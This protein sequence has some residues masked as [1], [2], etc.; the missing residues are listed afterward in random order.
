MSVRES[1]EFFRN[2]EA[3]NLEAPS[4]PTGS[5]KKAPPISQGKMAVGGE[6]VT[7]GAPQEQ[8]DHVAP[9]MENLEKN[10]TKNVVEDTQ[11]EKDEEEQGRPPLHPG[12]A[13][14]LTQP[15]SPRLLRKPKDKV[16]SDNRNKNPTKPTAPTTTTQTQA[17]PPP[18]KFSPQLPAKPQRLPPK[19]TSGTTFPT[20]SQPHATTSLPRPLATT[21]SQIPREINEAYNEYMKQK[22]TAFNSDFE[23]NVYVQMAAWNFLKAA[24]QHQIQSKIQALSNNQME[25]VNNELDLIIKNAENEI[26]N[27]DTY[28]NKM[29]NFSYV[30]KKLNSIAAEKETIDNL[31]KDIDRLQNAQSGTASTNE[32][33]EI[34]TKQGMLIDHLTHLLSELS[35]L[36]RLAELNDNNKNK[37]EVLKK[38]YEIFKVECEETYLSELE[39]FNKDKATS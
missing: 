13:T 31:K 17:K 1:F 27:N 35:E 38:G 37:I 15:K 2:L 34:E 6:T 22:N 8:S 7:S 14:P 39:K 11:K 18:P 32:L 33:I 28:Q 30:F 5:I 20:R 24:K 21:P 29:E 23:K 26:K 25:P 12:V 4:S 10:A 19:T 9:D 16:I 36:D 3:R